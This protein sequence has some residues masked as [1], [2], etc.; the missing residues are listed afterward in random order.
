MK[1]ETQQEV[2]KL[3]KEHETELIN[4]K[5]GKKVWEDVFPAKGGQDLSEHEDCDKGPP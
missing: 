4:D 1:K 2:R 5:N 3:L